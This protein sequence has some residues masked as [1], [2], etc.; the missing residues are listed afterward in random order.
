MCISAT[1][2]YDVRARVGRLGLQ[3]S[4]KER[5]RR[6]FRHWVEGAPSIEKLTLASSRQGGECADQCCKVG[7]RRGRLEDGR[8]KGEQRLAAMHRDDISILLA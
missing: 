5:Q 4:G 2:G 6:L 8:K 1:Q 7:R 3:L